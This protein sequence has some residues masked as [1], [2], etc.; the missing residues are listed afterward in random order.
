MAAL[1]LNPPCQG[2]RSSFSGQ[3]QRYR[4][5]I[6]GRDRDDRFENPGPGFQNQFVQASRYGI[7]V[8]R[9]ESERL[10]QG[11]GRIV[12]DMPFLVIGPPIGDFDTQ[13]PG[14]ARKRG[15]RI[16]K[17]ALVH[18]AAKKSKAMG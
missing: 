14:Q 5:G 4:K 11:D 3:Y 12:I 13:F 16:D 1:M 9:I 15:S 17:G 8:T 10:D 6:L 2:I 7:V 18:R